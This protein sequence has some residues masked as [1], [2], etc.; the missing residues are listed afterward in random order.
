MKYAPIEEAIDAI[1]R[2]EFLIVVDHE[3]RENEGDLILAADKVT[4]E[5]I[6]FMVRYTSGLICM[7][8]VGERLD[9]LQLP[10]MVADNTDIHRTSFTVSVDYTLDTTTGISA[11]DRASTI[12]AMIDPATRPSDMARPGHVFPLRYCEGGV[13][14][15]PG[16][17]EAAVDFARLAGLYPAGVLCE[18]V[19]DDGTMA[20]GADLDLFAK[21]HGIL[22]VTIDDLIAYRR[23]IEQLVSRTS[24][25]NLPTP[26]GEFRAIG[27]RDHVEGAEHLALVHGDIHDGSPVLVRVHSECLTGDVFRSRRCDCGDQLEMA[28]KAIVEA[29]AGV[30]VYLGGHE[31]RGIGLLDKIEAYALQEQ[32]RDTVEANLD[33]GLPADARDYSSAAQILRDLGVSSV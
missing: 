31:G 12:K 28:M 16:H 8:I 1:A 33:L 24:E 21:E 5:A 9:D 17:T 13:L 2:G 23:Q 3:D 27:Y 25:V 10:L 26:Q 19:N 29:G 32:G 6:A 20:R 15:R 22:L 11:E 18:I 14:R 7:P 4:P 30:V